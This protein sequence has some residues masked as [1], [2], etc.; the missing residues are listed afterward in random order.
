MRCDAFDL[1]SEK[2]VNATPDRL[3]DDS[4]EADDWR[5]RLFAAD[6][7]AIAVA[8]KGNA[9]SLRKPGQGDGLNRPQHL[10]NGLS[11]KPEEIDLLVI[12]H[13]QPLSIR[14][15][16]GTGYLGPVA[17]VIALGVH[18]FFIRLRD[19]FQC[20][21]QLRLV[22]VLGIEGQGEDFGGYP[23][24]GDQQESPASFVGDQR[25][26]IAC[27]VRPLKTDGADKGYV[28]VVN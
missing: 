7:N 6:E 22:A 2:Q 16:V 11:A 10:W 21:H 5:R 23:L 24:F 27:A 1:G 9:F 18:G 28:P 26:G 15:D 20:S 13:R 19:A 17:A 14:A 25:F 4:V 12:Q 8:G 3:L